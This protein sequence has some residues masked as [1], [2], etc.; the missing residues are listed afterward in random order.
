[1]K[2]W[3]FIIILTL[4][5]IIIGLFI[6]K[7]ESMNNSSDEPEKNMIKWTC[8]NMQV[9]N[10]FGEQSIVSQSL[11]NIKISVNLHLTKE[12]LCLVLLLRDAGASLFITPANSHTT[13]DSVVEYLK[14]EKNI[15]IYGKRDEPDE[16]IYEYYDK[17]LKSQPD[18]IIDD[19]A[20][21]NVYLFE[22]YDYYYPYIKN[23]R[24]VTEQ[25]ETGV[26][27]IRA[28]ERDNKLKLPVI[29]VNNANLKLL[30]DSRYG[31]AQSA[32]DNLTA[33]TNILMAGKICVIAGFGNVGKGCAL[34][35]SGIGLNIIVC[36]IDPIKALDA[37]MLGFRVM[38]MDDASSLGDV[39]ITMTGNI[40]VINKNHFRKMKDGVFLGN[41]GHGNV[42][43]NI[44]DL[45]NM[46]TNI[47]KDI[48]PFIDEYQINKKKLFLLAQGEPYNL[49]IGQGNSATSMSNS[50]C[51]QLKA[52][53]YGLKNNL[54]IKINIL[55]QNIVNNIG[56]K[57][58]NL[59]GYH[60]DKLTKEQIE[61]LNSDQLDKD[62]VKK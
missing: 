2:L 38:K 11:K 1:M 56:E 44:D 29:A 7:K 31:T 52:V 48:V 30:M 39:F 36:E 24:F 14:K 46:S 53:E 3:I 21:L 43:I 54:P 16:D 20:E 49:V 13:Q 26:I 22:N 23:M 60:I 59:F 12:T 5:L 37:S 57:Q 28:L 61:Y 42:E 19:G 50:F 35:M 15:I 18:V 32:I 58:L 17:S 25:T 9:L 10:F 47:I 4:I 34:R 41:L 6:N 8:N 62:F 45:K 40:N 51:L 55:P 27:R 33:T